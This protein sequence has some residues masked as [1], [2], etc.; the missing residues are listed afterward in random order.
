M[1][2][3]PPGAMPM[4]AGTRL[5]RPKSPACESGRL[6]QDAA[7][8]SISRAGVYPKRISPPTLAAHRHT[9]IELL[10]YHSLDTSV[11]FVRVCWHFIAVLHCLF[12]HI[13][14][15][16]ISHRVYCLPQTK[17]ASRVRKHEVF[18]RFPA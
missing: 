10:A 2:L 16:T 3:E 12:D 6:S 9:P 13:K 18:D 4:C 5:T 7:T 1:F 14:N 8:R 15:T 17:H 11:L